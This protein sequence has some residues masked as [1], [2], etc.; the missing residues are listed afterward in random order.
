MVAPPDLEIPLHAF[1]PGRELVAVMATSRSVESLGELLRR[2]EGLGVEVHGA[3]IS[4]RP[5]GVAMIGILD[6][7]ELGRDRG[8]GAI[9]S[10]SQEGV[11]VEIVGRG[12]RGFAALGGRVLRVGGARA[13]VATERILKG[14]FEGA[15]ELVGEE[16][17]STLLYYIGLLSGEEWGRFLRNLLGDPHAAVTTFADIVAS[18]G[19]ATSVVVLEGE[20]R[21]R[22]EVRDLV[23]CSL[24]SR[25][26]AERGGRMRTAHWSRGLIA[27][28]LSGLEGGRWDVD[29]VACVNE[30][31][32][33]CVFEA[34]R[35]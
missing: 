1:A 22:I 9:L 32:D 20:G 10:M 24:L 23:E 34:R 6:V 14:L 25:Y 17:G 5:E 31:Y 27:G 3:M 8:I 11:S 7:T 4:A 13:V 21:Y 19:Y 30:G 28:F 29:E 26:A 15:R 12:S 16:A 18:E 35:R 33:R 2:L